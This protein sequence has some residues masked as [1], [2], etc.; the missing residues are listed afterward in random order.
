MGRIF[1]NAGI[2]ELDKIAGVIKAAQQLILLRDQIVAE[3]RSRGCQVFSVPEDLSQGESI[4]WINQR[5]LFGDI[6]ISLYLDLS[7]PNQRGAAVFYISKNADR[8][9]QA[10][11]L[12]M[13]MLRR[14][15][16]ISS[17]GSKPDTF[18]ELGSLD[19][20]RQVV[21]PSLVIKIGSWNNPE[22]QNLILEKGREIALGISDGLI[23]WSREVAAIP[24]QQTHPEI[25]IKINDRSYPEQGITINNNPY[26]PIDVL[27]Q[28]A[29]PYPLNQI[30][31]LRE[32]GGIVYLK[33]IELREYNIIVNWYPPTYT[34]ELRSIIPISRTEID[35]IITNGNTSEVQLIMFLKSNN[36]NALN[37][38][39][40]LPKLYRQEA[41][42]EGVNHD[43]AFCQM[44]LET[45]FLR[46][47][48][49]IVSE[50]NNFASLGSLQKGK[51]AAFADR[52]LGVRAHIQ[53]LKGYATVEPLV[54]EIVD[55]R[56]HLIRRGIAPKISQLSGRWSADLSYGEKILSLL[57]RLYESAN[58]L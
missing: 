29:V 2:S 8:K 18:S 7:H 4:Q 36:E 15:P 48:K 24:P 13:L 23:G 21:I 20:C 43:V 58:L 47:G 52:Q 50:D 42:I 9:K 49:K 14:L 40:D 55:P 33:A 11:F 32:Y 45:D 22:D 25:A 46:F 39:P 1:I 31:S 17:L 28:L 12:L 19:F 26:I 53:H 34:L 27:D 44:C 38:F 57:T 37:S 5:A 41:K 51:Y 16:S 10:E 6:A 56:F 35:G 30:L 3:L 54:Q